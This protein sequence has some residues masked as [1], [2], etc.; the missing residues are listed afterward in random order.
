MVFVLFLF[1]FALFYYQSD[2][3]K[4]KSEDSLGQ[5]GNWRVLHEAGALKELQPHLSYEHVC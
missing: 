5:L 3:G 1:C 4:R 2:Y